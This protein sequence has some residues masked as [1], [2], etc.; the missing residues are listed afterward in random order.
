M[1]IPFSQ[2]RETIKRHQK[3]QDRTNQ[4]QHI[5]KTKA[6][7]VINKLGAKSK[8]KVIRT[9]GQRS[10]Q[11]ANDDRSLRSTKPKKNSIRRM[12]EIHIKTLANKIAPFSRDI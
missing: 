11:F 12:R 9:H 1:R 8:N 4:W 2:K 3:Q 5:I 7:L 6:K 10:Q